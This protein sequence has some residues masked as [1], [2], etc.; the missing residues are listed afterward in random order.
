M[1]KYCWK[2]NGD[3]IEETG[4]CDYYSCQLM[5]EKHLKEY[6]QYDSLENMVEVSDCTEYLCEKCLIRLEE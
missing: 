4:G 5:N 1:C 2:Y 6:G 3:G